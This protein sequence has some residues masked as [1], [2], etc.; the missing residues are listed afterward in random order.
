MSHHD[1]ETPHDPDP[2]ELALKLLL[3]AVAGAVSYLI[4]MWVFV[5]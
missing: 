5:R 4:M 3:Y 2:A 1:N